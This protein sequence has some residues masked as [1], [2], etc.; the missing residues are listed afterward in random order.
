M[1]KETDKLE[2]LELFVCPTV[3]ARSTPL[4]RYFTYKG[5][6][7]E[8]R[9]PK[10]E[11]IVLNFSVKWTGKICTRTIWGRARNYIKLLLFIGAIFLNFIPMTPKPNK[12]RK[13]RA[14]I[15]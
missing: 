1:H 14:P 6:G 9:Q 13:T 10:K 8:R 5:G 3:P 7:R 12:W 2:Y 15:V 4:Q 11:I